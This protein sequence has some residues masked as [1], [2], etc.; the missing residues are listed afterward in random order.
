MHVIV[1]II[2]AIL[3]VKSLGWVFW[4]VAG[5]AAVVGGLSWLAAWKEE[6]SLPQDVKDARMRQR[7]E[8]R[9]DRRARQADEE[10]YRQM[11]AIQ[12]QHEEEERRAHAKSALLG[13]AGKIA[14][15]VAFKALT[16]MDHR[17]H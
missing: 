6:E 3:I 17:H 12:Q 2:V 4:L 9:R 8:E 16:G 14:V 1:G 5:V 13:A 15:G 7:E 10:H 11:L